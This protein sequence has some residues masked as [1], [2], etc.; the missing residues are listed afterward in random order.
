[1]N[2]WTKGLNWTC[3]LMAM[4]AIAAPSKAS[5]GLEVAV[6][7]DINYLTGGIGV[8]ERRDMKTMARDYNVHIWNINKIHKLT[9]PATLAI[10]DDTGNERIKIY[11]A[12]PVIFAELPMGSYTVKATYDDQE[13]EQKVVIKKKSDKYLTFVWDDGAQKVKHRARKK[14]SVKLKTKKETVSE[15]KPAKDE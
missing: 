8:E 14:H 12:D 2:I 4:I 15:T 5:D 11:N 7:N 3:L 1:M 6:Q 9:M 13:Q 10:L